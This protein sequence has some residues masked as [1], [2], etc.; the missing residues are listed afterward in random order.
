MKLRTN[1]FKE[2]IKDLGRELDVKITYMLNNETIMLTSENLNRVNPH[3]D[4]NILKSVMKELEIDSNVDIPKNV[5]LNLKIGVKVNG[6]YEY[7]NYGNYIVYSSKKQEDTNSYIINCYDKMIYSMIDY[8][9]DIQYPVSIRDY[10]KAIC[11]KIGLTFANQN[12]TFANYDKLINN[13]LYKDLGYKFRDVLDELAQ[14]TAS[15]IC[16]NEDDEL[17]IRYINNTND[18]IDEEF[19]NDTNVTFEKKYG[20]INSVVLSRSA[21]S[22]V[23]YLKDDDSI[24]ENGL[25][26]LKIVDNQ[27]MN[28][29]DRSNYLPDILE[30]IGG[31]EFYLNDFTLK[32]VL[33]Y[34]LC[35]KYNVIIGN[36]TYSCVMLN[37]DVILENGLEENVYTDTLKETETDYS[38][39]DKTDRRI[40]QAYIILNKQEKRLDALL[41]ETTET[42]KR[43]TSLEMDLNGVKTSVEN[44]QTEITDLKTL[45]DTTT[46]NNELTINDA[47]EANAIEYKIEGKSVSSKSIEGI[48]N[49]LNKNLIERY[50]SYAYGTVGVIP[51]IQASSNAR[52]TLSPSNGIKI[53]PNTK[54][55]L[56]IPN[57]FRFAVAQ[58]ES[59]LKSLGDTGWLTSSNSPYTLATKPNAE[60]IGF[61]F[62]KDDNTSFSDDE[63]DNFINGN[64]QFEEGTVAHSYVPY[65]CYLKI[66]NNSEDD[67]EDVILIPLK[68]E[69]L[70]DKDNTDILNNTYINS[71]NKKIE[72]LSTTKSLYIQIEQNRTYTILKK[73]SA[74]FIVSTTKEVPSTGIVST[75]VVSNNNAEKLTITSSDEDN[76]LVIFYYKSDVDT[77]TEQDILDSIKIYEGTG[78]NDY[79]SLESVGD[80]RDELEIVNNRA[81]LHK[82]TELAAYDVDLGQV[83]IPL[84]KG[85]NKLT[86]VEELETN[87]SVTYL[88]DNV[89]NE[90]FARQLDLDITKGEL[91]NTKND[92]NSLGID[93]HNSY[94]DLLGK[95]NELPN[96][97][98]ITQI[99][100]KVEESLT[101]TEWAVNRVEEIV[102]NGATQ[103][104]TG[105]GMTF[106]DD[107]LNFNREGAPVGSS[108][109]EAGMKIVDKTGANEEVIQYTGYVTKEIASEVSALSKSEGS[110]VNYAESYFF[111]QHIKGK[112][113]QLEE[114]ED[115]EL[116]K[117]WG[118]Y[119]GG[120]E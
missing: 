31:L 116:G 66:K 20:P 83:A 106:N 30:K 3:Y 49:L 24:E 67:E 27:I 64:L 5:T 28:W 32:G 13:D 86:L 34:D 57:G 96:G 6:M 105:N 87:T 52:G 70:F 21:E 33:Y 42:S 113:G 48:E 82:R 17:E 102:V 18:T 94:Q 79:W 44:T 110:V 75:T 36:K 97:D 100:Q 7:L 40:N 74:R 69:N 22:D 60:Y 101:S 77:L 115:D 118:I 56:T 4:G 85:Y 38:K 78:S 71:A 55:T 65:G 58:L 104:K 53:K 62:G 84:R 19:F 80:V 59:D 11:T 23:V 73:L 9:L 25:N 37:D 91:N 1:N 112:Y 88:K 111:G 2:Q 92:V 46:S 95:I 8:E 119:V 81:I 68:K 120:D 35:D 29:N 41:S 39:A 16:L 10:L 12:V 26:E 103:V 109:D 15:T 51:N 47:L 50:Y 72:N 93:V 99:N 45:K 107:G 89:L 43:V 14:I 108:V 63:W 117:G 54:Y 114:I 90:E 76:Y 98:L 61:N